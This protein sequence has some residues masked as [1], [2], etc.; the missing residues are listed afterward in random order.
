MPHKRARVEGHL[1]A[2]EVA[3]DVRRLP[4]VIPDHSPEAA[5]VSLEAL[6]GVL[7]LL[8]REWLKQALL[9]LRAIVRELSVLVDFQDGVAPNA[10]GSAEPFFDPV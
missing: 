7:L 5:L 10:T 6:R 9:R 4:V 1:H 8:P 3:H 2:R